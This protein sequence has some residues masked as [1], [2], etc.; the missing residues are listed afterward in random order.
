V[1]RAETDRTYTVGQLAREFS[2]PISAVLWHLNRTPDYY[3]W[4]ADGAVRSTFVLVDGL[5]LYFPGEVVDGCI[6]G[7]RWSTIVNS[8]KI[9]SN[10]LRS[11]KRSYIRFV[12]FLE[13]N[14]VSVS[15]SH[16]SAYD[17]L[18]CEVG[19]RF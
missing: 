9:G 2:V 1:V 10:F 17:E 3:C 19:S 12:R 16:H 5:Q 11:Q 6:D 4:H 7:R 15:I 18:C 14:G 13:R 8:L